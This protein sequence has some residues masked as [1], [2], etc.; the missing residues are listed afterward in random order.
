MIERFG[1][2]EVGYLRWIESNPQGYIVNANAGSL[3]PQYPMVHR[4][5]HGSMA[6]PMRTNYTS[7]D[8]IKL[9]SNDPDELKLT[10]MAR[11]GRALNQCRTCMGGS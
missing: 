7:G 4:T 2:D 3:S 5:S 10:S 1:N 9:C 6:S 8:Y 11:D